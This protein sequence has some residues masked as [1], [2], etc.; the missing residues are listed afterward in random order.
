M[1]NNESNPIPAK[2]PDGRNNPAY[3]KRYNNDIK[4]KDPVKFREMNKRHQ[5][6]YR[7]KHLE[8]H[9]EYMREYIREWYQ[10]NKVIHS[11]RNITGNLADSM[12]R[13]RNR[14][15][16]YEELE[17]RLTSIGWEPRNPD[18]ELNHIVS[19][20]ILV[21]FGCIDWKIVYDTMNL[22]VVDVAENH[23]YAARVVSHRQL[24]I[25]KSLECKYPE[26]LKGFA[27]HIKKLMG[28]VY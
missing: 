24:E 25:A 11:L 3:A 8:S 16:K 20:K 23:S 21:E 18:K 4:E 27:K 15:E 13:G 6:T 12:M 17:R 9:R 5:S 1:S 2:L 28:V 26:Q 22:E 19:I 10:R 7:Q 14:R